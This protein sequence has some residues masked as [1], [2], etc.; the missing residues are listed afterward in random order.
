MDCTGCRTKSLIENHYKIKSKCVIAKNSPN[1]FCPCEVC[2]VKTNCFNQCETFQKKV[3]SI[4][5]IETSYDYKNIA[6][7]YKFQFTTSGVIYYKR[8]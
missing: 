4:F 6:I 2:I 3:D 1:S 8:I 7:P 5:K